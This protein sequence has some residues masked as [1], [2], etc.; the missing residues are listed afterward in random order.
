VA[1]L[2]ICDEAHRLAG[3]PREAFRV[4]LDRR[5]L[6][7]R[8]RLFMTATATVVDGEGVYSMDDAKVFGPVAH[9]VTFGEAIA[10]GL[11]A[12][13]PGAGDSP[14]APGKAPATNADPEQHRARCS[15]PSINTA[16]A[17]C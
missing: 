2:A 4:V 17:G 6:I 15:M 10:A 14:A 9:T 8:K 13:L 7:A 11:L 12:D 3:R 1:D 16:S 5:R